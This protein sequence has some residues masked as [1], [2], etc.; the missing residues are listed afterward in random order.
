MSKIGNI[1]LGKQ[2]ITENFIETLKKFFKNRENVRV[3]VLRSATRDREEIKK[4]AE[5]ILGDLG[6]NFTARIIGFTI[7]VKKW[8]KNV[9]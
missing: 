8:R 6:K 3:S 7:V 9:R 4:F 2:K 5:K 1:Q